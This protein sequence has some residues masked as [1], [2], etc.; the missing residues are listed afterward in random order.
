MKFFDR[1][2][3]PDKK[4]PAEV[5]WATPKNNAENVSVNENIEVR[6]LDSMD[7][8]SVVN[9]IKIVE[10]LTN[11]PVSGEWTAS[12]V[13]M[14]FTFSHTGFK[15]GTIY[16][17]EIPTSVK[18]KDGNNLEKVVIKRFKTEGNYTLNA[19]YD[20]YVSEKNPNTVY[21]KDS[22]IYVN[23]LAGDEKIAFLTFDAKNLSTVV[24]AT[25]TIP[26]LTEETLYVDIYVL[27]DYAIDENTLT[28]ANMP[29]VTEDDF[30]MSAVIENATTS[31][32][33]SD[34]AS[35]VTGDYVTLVIKGKKVE[36]HTLKLDFED[37]AANTTLPV[38]SAIQSNNDV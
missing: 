32:G 19:I 7:V 37:I 11:T 23:G 35:K 2:L 30:L 27:D 33:V 14:M 10:D 18:T 24:D 15:A 29:S 25:L 5:M 38:G 13:D 36:E 12:E 4:F 3:K 28:Y 26:A 34:I 8:Q 31:I 1:Y 17:V 21:G 6:F 22:K 20:T 16:R 9:N